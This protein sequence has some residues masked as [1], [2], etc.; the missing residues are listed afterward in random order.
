E[1]PS[2]CG[3]VAKDDNISQFKCFFIL[4]GVAS[5]NPLQVMIKTQSDV[6]DVID[7]TFSLFYIHGWGFVRFW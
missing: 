5:T 1:S 7:V 2:L 4:S 3:I 6:G